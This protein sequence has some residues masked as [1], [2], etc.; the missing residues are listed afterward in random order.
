MTA[1]DP[2]ARMIAQIVQHHLITSP[3]ERPE[4]PEMP[5]RVTAIEAHAVGELDTGVVV[6]TAD[7]GTRYF[8]VR[9]AEFTT[10]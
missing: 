10:R 5:A 1:S 6:T 9:V 8:L 3:A 4:L 7:R 2:V